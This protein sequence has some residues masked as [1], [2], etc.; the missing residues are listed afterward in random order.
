M[1]PSLSEARCFLVL[2]KAQR[3]PE[4][5]LHKKLKLIIQQQLL[6]CELVTSL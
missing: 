2:Q 6:L 5:P 1:S 4:L 3:Q